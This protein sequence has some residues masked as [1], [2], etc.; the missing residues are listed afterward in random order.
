MSVNKFGQRRKEEQQRVSDGRR[1]D[2]GI[3]FVLTA[4]D[5][6]DVQGKRLTAVG[7][8]KDATDAATVALVRA[9]ED[10][11]ARTFATKAEVNELALETADKVERV[12]LPAL[13]MV[14][15][16]VATL[17]G[18]MENDVLAIDPSDG[19]Y[20]ASKKRI[21]DVAFPS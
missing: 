4:D 7:E 12:I 6:F 19:N 10:E 9:L 15:N 13:E 5:D 3:G 18:K 2:R 1:G 11:T 20:V 14:T 21:R 8:P 16:D 17:T